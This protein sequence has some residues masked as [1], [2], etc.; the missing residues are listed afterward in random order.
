MSKDASHHS[1]NKRDSICNILWLNFKLYVT[2]LH[3]THVA[4]QEQNLLI[5]TIVSIPAI[6]IF[7][8]IGSALL[9]MFFSLSWWFCLVLLPS[10][11]G[12]RLVILPSCGRR[13]W[14]TMWIRLLRKNVH[15]AAH[16]ED[17]LVYRDLA[18]PRSSGER[19]CECEWQWDRPAGNIATYQYSKIGNPLVLTG[20]SSPGGDGRGDLPSTE[21]RSPSGAGGVLSTHNVKCYY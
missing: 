20:D 8:S 17:P 13:A 3:Q 14:P 21:D 16:H 5:I 19:E 1:E 9:I 2:R 4:V 7:R 6:I 15:S 11:W 18:W 12:S 10:L